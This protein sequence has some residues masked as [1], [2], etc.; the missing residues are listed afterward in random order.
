MAKI[1]TEYYPN[2]EANDNEPEVRLNWI[3]WNIPPEV[4][5][6]KRHWVPVY[7]GGGFDV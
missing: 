4:E 7:V 3:D 5:I 1:L 6:I 2:M